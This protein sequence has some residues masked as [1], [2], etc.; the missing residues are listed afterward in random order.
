MI[1][2]NFQTRVVFFQVKDIST[3]LNRIVETAQLHFERKENFLIIVEDEKVASYVDD[4][5]W[6]IGFLPHIMLDTPSSEK[7]VITKIKQ[8]LN[9][10]KYVFN[11]CPAPLFIEGPFKVIY[12]LEDLTAPSKKNL[13]QVRFEGYKNQGR[14]LIEAR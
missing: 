6:K 8:N 1:S 14:Y 10:S 7:V 13:S 2:N 12:E 9:N 5:L 4:L 3:K 11:L